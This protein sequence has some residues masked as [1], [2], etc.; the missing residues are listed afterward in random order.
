MRALQHTLAV[1]A[2]ATFVVVLPARVGSAQEVAK[3][4]EPIGEEEEIDFKKLKSP[5]PFT[6]KSIKRGLVIYRRLCVECHGPDGK[7][8]IDVIADATDLTEPEYYYNGSTEGEVFRSI[9]D[10][11][12][13]NMPPYKDEIRKTRD[14]WHLVNVIRRF[15]PKADQPELQDDADDPDGENAAPKGRDN[16]E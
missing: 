2:L 3:E 8:Q 6:T 15:W 4:S 9:R 13:E 12:G 10:G 7:S 11:A 14:I 5:V 1:A 16:D